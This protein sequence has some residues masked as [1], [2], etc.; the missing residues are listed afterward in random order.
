MGS[1]ILTTG[2]QTTSFELKGMKTDN[3]NNLVLSFS[4]AVSPGDLKISN[5]IRELTAMVD[6]IKFE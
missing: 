6:W 1:K 5:D 4:Y 3:Y 2:W